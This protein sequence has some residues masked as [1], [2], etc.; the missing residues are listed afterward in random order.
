MLKW[1]AVASSLLSI[2]TGIAVAD[3]PGFP[4][5]WSPDGTL[6][7]SGSDDGKL[8]VWNASGQRLL[9]LDADIAP[10]T[11]LAWSP[12]SRWLAS[13]GEAISIWDMQSGKL[14]Y[15]L[16]VTDADELSL[17]WNPAGS[18][19][20]AHSQAGLLQIWSTV[21]WALISTAQNIDPLY[22]RWQGEQLA[23]N[24]PV[25]LA[26]ANEL[27]LVAWNADESI[28][29]GA[30]ADGRI[31]LWSTASG[32][33]IATLSGQQVPVVQLAFSPTGQ[34]LLSADAAGT[35]RIW[36]LTTWNEADR[37]Q[38]PGTP[39]TWSPDGSYLAWVTADH[40]A[41]EIYQAVTE[42]VKSPCD[43]CAG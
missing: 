2:L 18:R 12:D 3:S 6:I 28:M 5:V 22:V 31:R 26:A 4:I 35:L 11:S 37:V 13:A 14:A 39:I 9:N 1:L 27:A 8:T 15:T 23:L 34:Q 16:S 42:P 43:L 19:L 38:W 29:A 10:V 32:E 25:A 20:A 30:Q 36:D 21:D 17:S 7:V 40:S 41:I 24:A 33:R